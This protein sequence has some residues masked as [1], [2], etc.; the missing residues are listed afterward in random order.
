MCTSKGVKW[1]APKCLVND[2]SSTNENQLVR[3][4]PKFWE[5]DLDVC[6]VVLFWVRNVESATFT[7][8]GPFGPIAIVGRGYAATLQS[9]QVRV[10]EGMWILLTFVADLSCAQKQS[11]RN[12]SS[13][14]LFERE[15]KLFFHRDQAA[16]GMELATTE[17]RTEPHLHWGKVCIPPMTSETTRTTH[18]GNHRDVTTPM[19]TDKN[20]LDSSNS[21]DTS[22]SPSP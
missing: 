14:L 15:I 10:L 3:C 21:V 5:C 22:P 2:Q 6:A 13:I 9:L 4:H 18:P 20:S 1:W 11:Y 8:A 19:A 17:E 16:I 7:F 12:V